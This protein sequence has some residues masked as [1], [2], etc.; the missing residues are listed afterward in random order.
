MAETRIQPW[1]ERKDYGQFKKL[2]PDDP[3]LPDT[4]EQWEQIAR[5]EELIFKKSGV[6]VDKVYIYPGEVKAYC[7]ACKINPDGVARA[8]FAV[9]KHRPR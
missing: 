4:F 7:D 3:S 5:E 8:A 6:P 1:F 9:Q 2:A